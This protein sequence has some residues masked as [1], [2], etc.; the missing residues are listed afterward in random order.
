MSTPIVDF[1]NNDS[2]LPL[3]F[4]FNTN[5]GYGALKLFIAFSLPCVALTFLVW[6]GV[7]RYEKRK[8]KLEKIRFD[9]E[10]TETPC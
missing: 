8:E 10:K 3:N 2:Y 5:V 1:S 6:L 9:Q 4:S 7:H